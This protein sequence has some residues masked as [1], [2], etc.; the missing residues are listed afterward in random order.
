MSESLRKAS[1]WLG[2]SNLNQGGFSHFLGLGGPPN[3]A[4]GVALPRDVFPVGSGGRK[5]PFQ[6]WRLF[7][8]WHRGSSCRW[9]FFHGGSPWRQNEGGDGGAC[10]N[11]RWYKAASAPLSSCGLW[12]RVAWQEERTL[13]QLLLSSLKARSSKLCRYLLCS[14]YKIMA[15]EVFWVS[16]S[17]M[18]LEQAVSAAWIEWHLVVLASMTV[19]WKLVLASRTAWE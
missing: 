19:A 18:A 15:W 13:W 2:I 12:H 14:S 16:V 10:P 9:L 11:S 1:A 7:R 5:L 4:A 17:L 3:A 6:S 8:C